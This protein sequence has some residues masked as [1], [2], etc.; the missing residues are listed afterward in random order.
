MKNLFRFGIA[1]VSLMAA[2][3]P[4]QNT[5]VSVPTKTL[6]T[7]VGQYELAPG[8]VLTIRKEGERLTGQATGQPAVRLLARSETE[9]TINGVEASL[10]FVKSQNGK[11][12]HLVLHQNGDHEASKISDTVPKTRV[13]VQ[14]PS[15]ALEACVGQYELGPGQIL[16]VRRDGEKLRAQLTG[17]PSFQIFPETETNFF[18]KVVD[19]QITFVRGADNK[20]GKLILHQNGDKPAHKTSDEAPPIKGPDLSKIP[21]RDAK[22]GPRL[23]DLTGKYNGVLTEPWHPDANGLPA[24]ANHL[25]SLPRGVQKLGDVDFD[26][27]GVVQV[28]GTQAEFAGAAFPDAVTGIKVGRKCKRLHFLHATGWRAEEGTTI[29]QYVLHYAEGETARLNIVYGVDARDWWVSGNEPK[30]AKSA[31]VAWSGSNP[32]SEA[33]GT[34]VRLFKRTYENPRPELRLE[35]LDLVS[36]QADS[37]PFLVALTVED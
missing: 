14:V 33:A 26:V 30:E 6:E 31:K 27:R 17:Q 24:G 15:K 20:V 12:S 36:S 16:T 29:G 5:N 23:I 9:F 7:Y 32:A 2:P 10:T 8:F 13:A 1:A 11:V 18:Y 19:A 21:A 4:A 28:T 22:A 3:L 37:A 25:G 35:T 34:S